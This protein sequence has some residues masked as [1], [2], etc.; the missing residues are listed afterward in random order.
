MPPMSLEAIFGP[1]GAIARRLHNYEQRPQQMEMAQAIA[2]AIAGRKHF[3]VEAGT[4]VGKSFAYLVPALQ[5]ALADKDCRVVVSTQTISLQEQLIQKDIP[6][7]QSVLPPFR[8]VLVKGRSNYLS[9]RRLH[10]AWQHAGNLFSEDG[11]AR[12]L[13]QIDRWAARTKDG[14]R[15]DLDFEPIGSVW[16]QVESDS[17]NCLGRKCPTYAQCF[18]FQAR[19]QMQNAHLLVVNHALLFSDLALRR[20]GSEF[21]LLPKY[22]VAIL[23]EGHSLE[24]MA[25]RHL[26]LQVSS[27]QVEYHLSRLFSPRTQRGLLALHGT[28]ESWR[29][30]SQ[31]RMAAEQFFAAVTDLLSLQTR[32]GTS[33]SIPATT[34]RIREA[35]DFPDLLA[36]ELK[37]LGGCLDDVAGKVKQE[38]EQIELKA[39]AQRSRS[40]A[41]AVE[42]WL[43]QQLAG[44]VYWIET[45]GKPG[46]TPI[47]TLASAPVEVATLLRQQ[48][49]EQVPTVI[50]TSATLS[51]GGRHGFDHLRHRLGLEECGTLQL[52]SPFNYRE[53]A[54]LHLFKNLPPP[55]R[56]EA[57]EDAVAVQIQNY[58]GRTHGRAFV[59]FTSYQI[60]RRMADRLRAWL[61]QRGLTLLTQGEGLPRQKMLE[62]FRAAGNAVLFGVDSFWQGVDVQG[63][64][65]SNVIITKLPF[66]VPDDPITEA[67]MEAITAAGGNAFQEYQLPRAIIKLKQGFG[68][69]IRTREDRGLVVLLDPR[70]LTKPYGGAFLQALPDCC[71][72]VD[73]VMV[74]AHKPLFN[75]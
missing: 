40:L 66:A 74:E 42:Q 54:E 71:R 18:Y 46:R 52:G 58:V 6:F 12:Q 67:R 75:V 10:V 13:Q 5:A 27:T 73:G 69:L 30:V 15:S 11:A 64:A 48:L 8:A 31:T 55:T 23:D 4:G 14:S 65:L 56:E 29:Q 72:F 36:E 45:R 37:K 2:R 1:D 35:A 43:G 32:K 7:L 39:A 41:A 16:S 53:Q 44:Q 33:A 47:V 19:R 57:F 61:S 3:M 62:R 70:V 24:D 28:G 25:A 9:L 68:R 26:G 50:L 59:L 21:G 20:T 22:R 63:E 34:F 49:W 38:E 17:N 51:I 60:L